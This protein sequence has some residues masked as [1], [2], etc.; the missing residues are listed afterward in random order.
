LKFLFLTPSEA[1]FVYVVLIL[2]SIVFV[3]ISIVLN[4]WK[5]SKV[6]KK[7]F[8]TYKVTLTFDAVVNV[9]KINGKTDIKLLDELLKEKTEWVAEPTSADGCVVNM[10]LSGVEVRA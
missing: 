7:E 8:D 5:G 2:I 1:S 9:K 6:P 4:I 3:I 10:K